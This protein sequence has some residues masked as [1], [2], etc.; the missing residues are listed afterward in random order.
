MRL[1]GWFLGIPFALMFA[2]FAVSNRGQVELVLWPLPG[3]VDV[4]VYLVVML[5]LLVGFIL[6]AGGAILSATVRRKR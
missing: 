6:G 5:A 2:W 4:P 1:P 3:G